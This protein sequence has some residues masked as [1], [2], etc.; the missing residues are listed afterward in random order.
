MSRLGVHIIQ[1]PRNY[2]GDLLSRCAGAGSPVPLVKVVEVGDA[3]KEAK[4]YSRDTLTVFRTKVA[5]DVPGGNFPNAFH[6]DAASLARG[7]MNKLLPVWLERAGYTDYFESINE[8]VPQSASAAEYL[9]EFEAECANIAQ[10]EL[11]ARLCA[12]N[13]ASGSP[14]LKLWDTLAP[15]VGHIHSLG[16]AVGLHMYGLNGS[17][18]NSPDHV[19]RHREILSRLSKLGVFCRILF[20]EC[21]PHFGGH[22]WGGS[23]FFMQQ[24]QWLDK[25][26]ADDTIGPVALF[27][28]GGIGEWKNANFQDI[29]PQLADWIIAHPTP[30]APEPQPEPEPEDARYAIVTDN[31]QLFQAT[32][33]YANYFKDGLGAQ[34]WAEDA[35]D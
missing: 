6:T 31:R 25:A 19:F 3:L 21:A 5:G 4:E 13:F 23:E 9:G 34:V 18:T 30:G 26:L 35:D 10:R 29:L 28:L 11:G 33:A 12:F 15:F 27:T 7:W 1:G 20:T 17:F 8:S 2:Y 24:C 14:D 16:G 32:L 22:E